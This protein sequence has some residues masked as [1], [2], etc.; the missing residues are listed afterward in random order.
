M[1][2]SSTLNVRFPGELSDLKRRGDNVLSQ[3]GISTTQAIRGLYQHLDE[4]QQVPTWLLKNDNTGQRRREL[5]RQ[6]VGIAPLEVEET[7]DDLKCE[8]LSRITL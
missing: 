4:T 8:R 3:A 2:Q 1:S 6:L 5:M 7:L